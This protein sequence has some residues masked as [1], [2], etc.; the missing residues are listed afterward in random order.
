MIRKWIGDCENA[1]CWISSS[2]R[3]SIDSNAGVQRDRQSPDCWLCTHHSDL[4]YKGV[5]N[6]NIFGMNG[7]L[8]VAC[9]DMLYWTEYGGGLGP[10]DW[11]TCSKGLT[12]SVLWS[13]GPCLP[14][15]MSTLTSTQLLNWP[16]SHVSMWPLIPL[17]QWHRLLV[18]TQHSGGM[19]RQR[20]PAP[21]HPQLLSPFHNM[22]FVSL[23]GPLY[24]FK[25]WKWFTFSLQWW[26]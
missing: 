16:A 12:V 15:A 23:S 18:N 14:S 19:S 26:T 24:L 2:C 10:D 13:D 25:N 8:H 11:L 20:P 1:Q 5:A 22:P 17:C 4:W 9:R 6:W 3:S 21:L 7:W